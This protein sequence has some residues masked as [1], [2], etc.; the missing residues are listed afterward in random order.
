MFLI[1]INVDRNKN[2]LKKSENYFA[3]LYYS[4][5]KRSTRLMSIL[6]FSFQKS[7]KFRNSS[8][9]K[10]KKIY[11]EMSVRLSWSNRYIEVPLLVAPKSY[12]VGKKY[13]PHCIPHLR[14]IYAAKTIHL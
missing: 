6:H 9:G 14:H 2:D 4:E 7:E 10:T 12:V 8:L 3:G 11:E 13:F 1:V 5:R